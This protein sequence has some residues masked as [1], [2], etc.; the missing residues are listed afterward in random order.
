MANHAF[1]IGVKKKVAKVISALH[2]WSHEV[3]D[4]VMFPAA[5]QYFTINSGCL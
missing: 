3:F 4:P 1:D 2:S 5:V